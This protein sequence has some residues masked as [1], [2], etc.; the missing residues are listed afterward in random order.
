MK[1]Y[2]I[3]MRA[4]ASVLFS[5]E[6]TIRNV[7]LVSY[8]R[9]AEKSSSS[10]TFA[11]IA[12]TETIAR[13]KKIEIIKDPYWHTADRNDYRCL[14][15]FSDIAHAIFRLENQVCQQNLGA[16]VI[17]QGL[18]SLSSITYTEK[19]VIILATL[20]D[21]VIGVHSVA[22]LIFLMLLQVLF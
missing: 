21:S 9:D 19:I 17:Y 8:S 6:R 10:R 12:E 5:L 11:W 7:L 22:L 18:L 2:K 4:L 20:H 15:V 16:V 13:H 1:W 14:P 3:W